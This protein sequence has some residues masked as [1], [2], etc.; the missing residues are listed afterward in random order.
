[1]KK[2][3][4]LGILIS[5]FFLFLV[6]RNINFK[7]VIQ[8]VANGEYLWMLPC[9]VTYALSFVFRSIRWKYLLLPVKKFKAKQ[10]FSSLIMG[11]AA[12]CI[13]PFRFGEI[14]RAYIVGKKHNVSKSASLATIVLERIM[15]G[16]GILFL[17]GI[18][19][20]YLE[21]IPPWTKK[22]VVI[23]ILLFIGS[24]VFA[25][26]LIV[27]KH[28]IDWL[29]K[30]PLL[31]YELKEKIISKIKKF[32]TGF[33]VITNVKGFIM[34]IVFS[35]CVWICE[36]FNMY[37][38]IKVMGVHLSFFTIIFVL[39][40]TVIGVTI[41]AAPGSIGTFEF[42]FVASM[43]FFGVT[44]ENAVASALMIHSFGI[45]FVMVLG[46]YFFFKEGISYKEIASAE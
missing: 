34:V 41:P 9:L 10:L 5:V 42:F 23:A 22:V 4:I 25:G 37:F 29:K 1:M 35:L 24:L 30:I 20:L 2:R 46:V 38:L 21:K 44:K 18:A 27:K 7:N 31:K 36:T 3:I 19:L 43:M 13:F 12:N 40:A 16:V 8:I 28:F 32:I 39:F 26:I 33:E 15:D 45:I 11:F 17:L 6:L 14:V